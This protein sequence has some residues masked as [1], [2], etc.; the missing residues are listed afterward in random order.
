LQGYD[1]DTANLKSNLF[2]M[3]WPP[4]SGHRQMFP[5]LDR[6]AWFRIEEARM[7]ILTGQAVFLDRLLAAS[8]KS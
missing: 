7:K 3:E 8:L 4:R 2:E 5:E 6:A 1:W